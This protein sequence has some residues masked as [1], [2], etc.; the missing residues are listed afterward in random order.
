MKRTANLFKKL[1]KCASPK[2]KFLLAPYVCTKGY[3][4]F[5][6]VVY[7][8]ICRGIA[9]LFYINRTC[10]CHWQ[11][12]ER[13]SGGGLTS[14]HKKDADRRL[15]NHAYMFGA[16]SAPIRFIILLKRRPALN[17]FAFTFNVNQF[18]FRALEFI[19]S[20]PQHLARRQFYIC[21]H[22]QNLYFV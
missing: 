5:T 13:A 1:E 6:C 14:S 3:C 11:L 9:R 20:C 8:F 19:R 4:F 16:L 15:I 2:F 7:N 17:C 21:A 22:T 18:G 12:R 10:C